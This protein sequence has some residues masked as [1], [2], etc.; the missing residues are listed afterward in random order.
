M[1]TYVDTSINEG[2]LF[3]VLKFM[4]RLGMAFPGQQNLWGVGR[5]GSPVPPHCPP[6]DGTGYL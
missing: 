5:Q 4:A 6:R 1:C 2:I 3:Q